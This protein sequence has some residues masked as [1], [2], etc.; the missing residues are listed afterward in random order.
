MVCADFKY[1]VLRTN[2]CLDVLSSICISNDFGYRGILDN[3]HS[4]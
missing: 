3:E 4:G 1:E 2:V